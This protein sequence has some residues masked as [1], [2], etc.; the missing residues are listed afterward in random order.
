MTRIVT[1]WATTTLQTAFDT[2]GQ[3]IQN[4]D[5]ESM[6]AIISPIPYTPDRNTN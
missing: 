6:V 4:Q 3:E 5:W 1:D 2:L